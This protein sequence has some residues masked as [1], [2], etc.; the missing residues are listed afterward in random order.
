SGAEPRLITPRR[1]AGQGAGDLGGA[2]VGYSHHRQFQVSA[3]LAM[4]L[5]GI[6]TYDEATY[7]GDV[8]ASTSSGFAPVCTGRSPLAIDFELGYGIG[9]KVDLFLELRIGIEQDFGPTPNSDEGPR[10]FHVSPG[11]RFF[12]SDAGRSKLFTTAQLVVDLGGYQTSGGEALG[13]DLGVRNLSGLWFDLDRAYGFYVF[14]GETATFARWLRFEL[15]A[16][17]GIQGR[18]R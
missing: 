7:C 8:D 13:A 16:G 5:R 14:I 9:R 3:R 18:Y 6:A 15:E 11:A 1:A 17:V 12:F 10:P 2:T 4:G